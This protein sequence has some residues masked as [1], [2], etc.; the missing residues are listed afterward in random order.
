LRAPSS[1]RGK[2]IAGTSP[3]PVQ[4]AR[5]GILATDG[6]CHAKRRTAR[7]VIL[8]AIG[9]AFNADFRQHS[10]RRQISA[11][12]GTALRWEPTPHCCQ[13]SGSGD[14]AFRCA[15]PRRVGPDRLDLSPRERQARAI[16]G[17]GDR[18]SGQRPA[19]R[20]R[21]CRSS[22]AADRPGRLRSRNISFVA[23]DAAQD[24]S[25]FR[26]PRYIAFAYRHASVAWQLWM[27][28]AGKWATSGPG[29]NLAIRLRSRLSRLMAI[30]A[31]SSGSIAIWALR[32]KLSGTCSMNRE[33]ILGAT[34]NLWTGET[35]ARA[36]LP[37][38]ASIGPGR[39]LAR[40]R[41]LSPRLDADRRNRI[42]RSRTRLAAKRCL[43]VRSTR[44]WHIFA[45]Q[46]SRVARFAQP[47]RVRSGGLNL[48]LPVGYDYSTLQATF[49]RQFVSLRPTGRER[50]IE[51][52]L[53]DTICRRLSVGQCLLADRTGP[54]RNRARRSGPGAPFQPQ[55]LIRR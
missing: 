13:C 20:A 9:R 10:L 35:G 48:T 6:R 26:Q 44:I 33:T 54:Y 52:S 23:A 11:Q 19:G 2:P 38:P 5:N 27:T 31:L 12:T 14:R 41:E 15:A 42:A 36:G 45:R 1:R 43:V 22:G 28:V 53:C 25:A 50:D 4:P 32:L 55:I 24:R 16:A 17:S 49:G 34:T 7:G 47:L 46:T 51:A 30:A 39:G 3:I 18:P 40:W 8:D 37:M 29:T 21:H